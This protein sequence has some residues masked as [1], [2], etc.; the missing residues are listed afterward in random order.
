MLLE[1]GMREEGLFR[2]AAGASKLKKLK[3]ALD[4]S[5]SQ[6]EEFYSDPHA[7]AGALKSYLR[8]LPEPLMTFSMYDEWIQASNISDPDKRL[9][10]LWVICDNL[11]KAHKANFR[12]IISFY[13]SVMNMPVEQ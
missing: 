12:Q 10:A 1:T 3:A 4:C 9:Q 6:L 7:V 5:T 11:P 8:E 13:L 2:I